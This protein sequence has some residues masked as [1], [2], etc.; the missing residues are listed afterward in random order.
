MRTLRSRRLNGDATGFTIVEVLVAI[1]LLSVVMTLATGLVIKTIDQNSNLTQQ[2]EAQNRNN[3]GME[4][5]TRAL[6]Q[7]VLPANGTKTTASIISDAQPTSVTFTTRLSSTAGASDTSINTPIVQVLA[8]FD[9][10]THTLKWGTGNQ[11]ACTAPAVCTYATPT[12]TKTLVYGV[13]NDG[14]TAVCS[15]NTSDGG[16]FHY[17]YVDPTGNLA[18]YSPSSPPAG[19]SVADISVV[20][21]DLWTQT[22]TGPQK[23]KCVA[24]TD[25][26]QLRNWQ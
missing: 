15:A 4:Q 25:Y 16:V 21:I 6:R 7:A 8:K 22:Q 23:P 19:K 11:N 24:L 12:L 18:A 2:G 17:W 10:V 9:T 14:G 5:L 1:M 20:Q 13:R 3:I 26:V